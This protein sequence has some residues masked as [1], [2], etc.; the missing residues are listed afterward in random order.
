[1]ICQV[2]VVVP[3]G[4]CAEVEDLL[5]SRVVVAHEA[6]SPCLCHRII[7]RDPLGFQSRA[8][9]DESQQHHCPVHNGPQLRREEREECRNESSQ[10]SRLDTLTAGCSCPMVVSYLCPSFPLPLLIR[11]RANTVGSF[12]CQF[13]PT[14]PLSWKIHTVALFRSLSL[15]RSLLLSPSSSLP[16][17]HSTFLSLSTSSGHLDFIKRKIIYN[18]SAVSFSDLAYVSGNILTVSP[19]V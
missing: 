16:G 2:G 9:A 19:T 14:H 8:H 12:K 11:H 10:R 15:Y 6:L 3:A 5:G 4:L 13:N 18:I 7:P 17:S 1:M